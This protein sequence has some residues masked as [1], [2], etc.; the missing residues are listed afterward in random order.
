MNNHDA[1]ILLQ[2]EK[3]G[4]LAKTAME[5][6]AD[7]DL[8]LSIIALVA[9]WVSDTNSPLLMALAAH[10]DIRVVQELASA[11]PDWYTKVSFP[12]D[13]VSLLVH[14]KDVEVAK[15]AAAAGD[16]WAPVHA[17]R[18]ALLR[19][20]AAPT[21][22]AALRVAIAGTLG[23]WF[24]AGRKEKENLR[25]LDLLLERPSDELLSVLIKKLPEWQP[26]HPEPKSVAVRVVGLSTPQGGAYAFSA[27]ILLETYP[28]WGQFYS[29]QESGLILARAVRENRAEVALF[30]LEHA[31]LWANLP[32]AVAIINGIASKDDDRLIA[33]LTTARPTLA[34]ATLGG[35]FIEIIDRAIVKLRAAADAQDAA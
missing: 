24:K 28:K 9:R 11:I 30:Y 17:R 10:R 15:R 6:V 7:T 1:E 8:A 32:A 25:V 4:A 5:L 13:L 34:T 23:S 29:A 22:P 16:T 19:Y 31:E 14:H 21:R 2:C 27:R 35:E 20:L 33:A 26:G 12:D 18:F 3:R